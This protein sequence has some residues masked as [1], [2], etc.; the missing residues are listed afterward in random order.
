LTRQKNLAVSAARTRWTLGCVS[1]LNSKPL[2]EPVLRRPDIL[3]RF[4]VPAELC[5]LINTGAVNAALLPIVDFQTSPRQLLLVPA[6]VISS[7][8]PTLTV[9]IFSRIVPQ[10][11]T[12]LHA[13]TDSHTSII[14]AQ[15]ILREVY[16]AKPELLPASMASG[17]RPQSDAQALLLIGDKVVNAAPSPAQYPHQLDLGLE[18]KKLTGLPFVFA[19]WMM[20][21]DA[22]DSPLAQIL[23][24]ARRDGEG[25]TEA[26][27]EHYA[28]KLGWPPDL[29]R[30]YFTE[31]MRYNVTPEG[32][33]AIEKFFEL[34]RAN[35]LLSVSRPTRYLEIN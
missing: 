35:D 17:P 22:P 2:I 23:S 10:N 4:A 33:R 6:G 34:A 1:Y 3:V 13:D 16:G 12:R 5:N 31:H 7:D 9:R 32:R 30:R 26:L 24:A 28:P 15:V 14:L 8:G 25:M 21:A 29:A 27:V 20:P 11:I 19:M 18:W